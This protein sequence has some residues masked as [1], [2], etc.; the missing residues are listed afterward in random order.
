M[1]VSAAPGEAK[2]HLEAG[3]TLL[4]GMGGLALVCSWEWRKQQM[5]QGG[6]V[7][8]EDVPSVGCRY[9]LCAHVTCPSTLAATGA[10]HPSWRPAMRGP[11]EATSEPTRPGGK[12]TPQ[13]QVLITRQDP[14]GRKSEMLSCSR[15]CN[16]R[17]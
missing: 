1:Q 7:R 2:A 15:S 13:G 3:L 16:F 9:H 6:G 12:D 11:G 14:W 4:K 8:T 10:S 17:F 5:G